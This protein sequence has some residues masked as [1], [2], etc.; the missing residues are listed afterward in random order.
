MIRH[1]RAALLLGAVLLAV[2]GEARNIAWARPAAAVLA[3]AVV[4]VALLL[5][6]WLSRGLRDQAR[7]A[8]NQWAARRG[9]QPDPEPVPK[10]GIAEAIRQKRSRPSLLAHPS[11]VTLAATRNHA[12]GR[13]TYMDWDRSQTEGPSLR[14][15]GFLIQTIPLLDDVYAIS[16]PLTSPYTGAPYSAPTWID[17]AIAEALLPFAARGARVEVDDDLVVVAC[18]RVPPAERDVLLDEGVRLAAALGAR[19][20]P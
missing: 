2:V 12:D 16:G 20:V 3:G 9:L 17:A 7:T 11:S 19:V 13:L 18:S 6:S 14:Y 5:D 1:L 8:F 10:H 4:V 15:S